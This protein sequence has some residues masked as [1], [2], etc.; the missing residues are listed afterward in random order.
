[1][2][3]DLMPPH[4]DFT[5]QLAMLCRIA[6]RHE[7]CRFR[8]PC[9]KNLKQPWWYEP[10]AAPSSKVTAITLHPAGPFQYTLPNAMHDP[11]RIPNSTLRRDH[12]CFPQKSPDHTSTGSSICRFSI[13]GI[14]EFYDY[15][16]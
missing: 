6:P 5:H 8:T 3:P 10:D 1:M 14:A 12:L 15:C 9:I 7:K 16:I 2:T 11:I 13:S 4:C